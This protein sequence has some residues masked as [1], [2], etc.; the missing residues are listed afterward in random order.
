MEKFAK[1]RNN[2]SGRAGVAER[3]GDFFRRARKD[4][5]KYWKAYMLVIPVIVYY[6]LFHYKPMYGLLIAFK[7]YRPAIGV[8]ESPWAGN[9]GFRHFID[10]FDSYYFGN[11]LK[12]TLVLSVSCLLFGFPAPIVLALL[13]NEIKNEKFKRLT[14]T[15]S[16]LP[17]FISLVVTCSLITTFVSTNGIITQFLG[18]F[19]VEQKSLLSV[20]QYFAPIYV[21]SNIWSGCGW[22]AIIYLAALSGIDQELYDAAKIDGAG[23]WKQIQHVTLPGISGTIIIMFLLR[24]GN[25]MDIGHEKIMLLYNPGIYETADVISTYVYR[26]GLQDYQWSYSAAVGLFNSVIN[27]IIVIVFNKLSKK[28]SEVSLW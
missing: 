19:G 25:L 4:I 12:N 21:I 8:L 1:R 28:Y 23:R 14:Q 26:S 9:F 15:I 3:C 2:G 10:F 13:L 18:L 16:Y 17:H 27:F 6:L 22:G 5:K 24:M 20:P 11:I 7:D